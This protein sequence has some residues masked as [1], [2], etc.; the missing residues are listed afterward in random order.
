MT[1]FP[2]IDKPWLKYYS[3]EA[4]DAPIPECTVYEYLWSQ[5]QKHLKNTAL[6]YFDNK[7]TFA[8]LFEN[9]HRSAVSFSAMGI[10]AN[11]IVTFVT[12]ST[13]ETVYAFFGLNYIGAISNMVDPRT[14]AEGIR[15][16]IQES[17]SKIV[18][19][20]DVAFDKVAQAVKDTSIEKIII[21]SPAD[22]LRG[23]KRW[24][25]LLTKTSQKKGDKCISWKDFITCGRNLSVKAYPYL[26][27]QCCVI[28]HTGGTTGTP[29]GV[30]LSNDN[31]NAM[32]LQSIYSGIDLQ[33]THTW[34]DIMPPF[35]AYGLGMGICLPLVVG[36]ETIL[37]PSFDPAKFDRLIIKYKPVHMMFVPSFWSSII[38]SKKLR[39]SAC[40]FHAISSSLIY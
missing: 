16:Y 21:V 22:S 1:G 15:N 32:V 31:I 3:E 39:N 12:V 33:R 6:N 37:I 17:N 2:S 20:L 19:A 29:K 11:D 8:E 28:V 7:I 34:L 23:V 38:Q 5:N 14:S 13:P 4:I 10:K 36:M 9:I 26:A 24:G 25:Y 18:L 35:I 27:N 30:M 40:L